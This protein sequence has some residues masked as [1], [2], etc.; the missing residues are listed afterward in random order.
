MTRSRSIT[1]PAAWS[2]Q[3][4]DCLA[5]SLPLYSMGEGTR[6]KKMDSSDASSLKGREILLAI[7]GG[8]AGYKSCDLVSKLVQR[9]AGVTVVM[10]TAATKFVTPLTF[11]TLSARPVLADAWTLP[12]SSDPQHIGLTERAD[13]MIV[14]PATADVLA[15]AAHGL[16]D[17]LVSLLINASACPVVF[18][19]SM[20]NRMWANPITQKNA[21]TLIDAGY[22]F[23]GPDAGW[24]ACRNVGAGRMSEPAAIVDFVIAQLSSK[25]A[26]RS[27]GESEAR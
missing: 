24:L 14:A 27:A 15:K 20:N 17:D 8:I 11:Q 2:I 16:C 23:I 13:L 18:A 9:G 10:T 3:G 22:Q 19:P 4:R 7:G 25:V 21:K 1:K 6:E 12:D 5:P 26:V